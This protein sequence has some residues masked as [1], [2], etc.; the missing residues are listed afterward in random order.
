VS[1]V[2]IAVLTEFTETWFQYY[3]KDFLSD[4]GCNGFHGI[5]G[6][7]NSHEIVR[8]FLSSDGYDGFHRIHGK[9]NN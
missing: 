4:G 5:N 7:V 9:I 8:D 3:N 2:V 6:N 1:C